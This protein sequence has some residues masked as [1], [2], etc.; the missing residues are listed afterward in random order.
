MPSVGAASK[1]IERADI[2]QGELDEVGARSSVKNRELE[3]SKQVNIRID[4]KSAPATSETYLER[5]QP[6]SCRVVKM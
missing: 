1:L 4:R 5:T 6:S 3:N 2:D